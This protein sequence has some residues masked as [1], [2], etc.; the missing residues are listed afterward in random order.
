MGQQ[1]SHRV[2]L[3]MQRRQHQGGAARAITCINVSLLLKQVPCS[4]AAVSPTSAA[5]R[6]AAE[7]FVPMRAAAAIEVTAAG[8]LGTRCS[9]AGTPATAATVLAACD[10]TDGATDVGC[11]AS[12]AVAPS[13]FGQ[14]ACEW[15]AS[16]GSRCPRA[17][18]AS[19]L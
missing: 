8:L 14:L 18:G 9:L 7:G 11:A 1:R 6:N 17:A 5:R 3:T 10:P 16:G 4:A 12:G 15:R 2:R 13:A 19:A